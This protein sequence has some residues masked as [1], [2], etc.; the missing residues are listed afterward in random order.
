MNTEEREF[1][2][3][4]GRSIHMVSRKDLNSAEMETVRI[5]KNPTTVVTANGEV[6]TKEEAT[7]YVRELDLFEWQFLH[8][9][10]PAKITGILT[11]GPVVKNHTSS[12]N[13]RK[14][15]C[16][17]SNHVPFVVPGLSTSSSTSSSPTSPTSYRRKLWLTRNIQQQS[18]VRLRVWKHK[19]T[20]RMDQQKSKTQIKMTTTKNYRVTSCKMCQITTGVQARSGRW[21]CSRTPR[22]YQFFSWMNYL[23]SREPKWYRVSTAFLL[24]SRS[25]EI[26]ILVWEPRLQGLLAENALVQSCPERIFFVILKLLDIII[27]TLWWYKTW[28]HN[29]YNPTHVKQTLLRKRKRAC[30]SSWSRRGMPKVSYTD[31][32]WNLANSA[33]TY[34]GIILRQHR[35]DR[36]LMGLLREQCVELRKGHLRCYCSQV[37]AMNGGRI[38]WNATAICEAFKV[39]CLTGKTPKALRDTIWRPSYPVWSKGRIS[40]YFR[41]R[42]VATAPIWSKILARYIPW[43]GVARGVECGKETY[44]SQTLRNWNRWTHLNSMQEDS[45]QWKCQRQWKVKS[46]YSQSQIGQS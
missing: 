34:H 19:E 1:V 30:K 22:R 41:Q 13:V 9:E 23:Q 4:S 33:E 32:S 37:W 39:S 7:V 10:N 21:K 3:D 25:T 24:T 6:L 45:M 11:S 44:W 26:A 14:I 2:V 20:C 35:T 40:P 38:P 31:K 18:E 16:D 5:S 43:I 29:G 42:P 28:Q 17:T 27:D 12:K 46:S 15:N 8:L 36:K